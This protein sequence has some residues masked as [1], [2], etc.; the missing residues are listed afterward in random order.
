MGSGETLSD[1]VAVSQSGPTCVS[2]DVFL[3]TATL[4][5]ITQFL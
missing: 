5:L 1:P 3:L 2:D 4:R